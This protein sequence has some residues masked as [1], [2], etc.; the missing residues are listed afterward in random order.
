MLLGKK[1]GI[2]SSIVGI[3]IS[4]YFAVSPVLFNLSP[5]HDAGLQSAIIATFVG[6]SFAVIGIISNNQRKNT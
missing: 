2:L 5:S 1:L 4:L 3:S 6:L